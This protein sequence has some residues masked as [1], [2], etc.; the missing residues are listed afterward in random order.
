[1]II[2]DLQAWQ[3][4]DNAEITARRVTEYINMTPESAKLPR[5]LSLLF[6]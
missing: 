2:G 5:T 1:M 6:T 3:L 4:H